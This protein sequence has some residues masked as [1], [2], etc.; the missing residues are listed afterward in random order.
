MKKL[1]LAAAASLALFPSA[2]IAGVYNATVATVAVGLCRYQLGYNTIEEVSEYGA[3]Y[4]SD[5]GYS[6]AAIDRAM[7]SP[8]FDD[9]VMSAIEAGGG[10]E[11]I[12]R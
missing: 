2:A 3:N 1:L 4:L 10:C 5:Q 12:T 9:D 8:T 6:D 7:N 11:R